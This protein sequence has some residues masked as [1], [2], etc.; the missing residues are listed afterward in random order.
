M[1]LV[2]TVV[3][4]SDY[5]LANRFGRIF[6]AS[7]EETVGRNGLNA[8]LN[9]SG[10]GN[11]IAAPPP[12]DVQLA[13]DTASVSAPLA[14]LELVYGP[15]GARGLAMRAGRAMFDRLV[16]GFELPTGFNPLAFRLLPQQTRLK[17]GIPA[18]ARLLK[19]H[20]DIACRVADHGNHFEYIAERCADCW[21]R[22]SKGPVCNLTV[23]LLLEA[24]SS[25]GRGQE[26]RVTQRECRAAGAAACVFHLDKEPIA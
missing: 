17:I 6:L 2:S 21:G 25:F 8:L 1:A 23:G 11:L 10:R 15:R 26:F 7:L 22:T 18:L 19:Q 13:F 5:F 24:M 16:D 12:D 9:L 14:A 3:P 20:S 4:P